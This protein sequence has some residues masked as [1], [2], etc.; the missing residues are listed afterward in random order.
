MSTIR[1]LVA[2]D[3]A[4]FRDGLRALLLAQDDVEWVGEAASGGEAIVKT[5]ELQ[6]DVIL[7]D[8][9]MPDFSGIEATGR[10]LKTH[11]DTK[12]IMVTML[13]D[14]ASVFAAMRVGARGYV[15][16]G[17]DA[18]E[19]LAVIRAVAQGQILFGAVMAQ[20]MLRFFQNTDGQE[21]HLEPFPDL[22]D[23]ERELLDLIAAGFSNSEIA[24]KLTISPKT[25]SNHIT[26]IFDKLQ[27]SDR[28]QAIVKA[29]EA[30]LG[31][32]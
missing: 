14:D 29:R 23:R 20:R 9:N 10:I 32:E 12:V 16:K 30:G 6:P 18:N 21:A 19:M 15:L 13:E 7:M 22:T 8:I 28:A 26:N 1:T 31:K 24:Q 4:L 17:S 3:H 25:V 11:P 27:V 5:A 2:D